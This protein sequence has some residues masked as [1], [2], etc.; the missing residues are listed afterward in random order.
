MSPK[1]QKRKEADVNN[2]G[3]CHDGNDDFP[4]ANYFDGF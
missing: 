3:A 4:D 2:H 1:N